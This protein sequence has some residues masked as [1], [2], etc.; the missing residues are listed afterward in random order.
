[1]NLPDEIKTIGKTKEITT[2]INKS[3]F[4][5]QVYPVES[6]DAVKD[7]LTKTKKKYHDASH[8]CYAYKLA[9]GKF[10][11]TDAGEPNGTAG[12]RILNA[13]EHF[14]LSN[15]LVIV[16]RIFGGIKLGVGPLGKAYYES[17]FQILNESKITLKHL[18]EKVSIT[19]KFNQVSLVHRILTHFNSIILSTDYAESVSL[20]CLIMPG[21]ID[22][23]QR[24]LEE[25]GKNNIK[26]TNEADF[27]YK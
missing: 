2:T 26:F 27:I 24:I 1:M 25:S 6:E 9:I 12:I 3:R 8:H 21:T 5:A 4:I 10:H 14:K 18:Y 15:Q 11:Y 13:I 23:I 22:Q 17:A 20:N 16:S 19:A 7:Y